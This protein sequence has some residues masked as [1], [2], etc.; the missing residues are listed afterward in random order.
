VTENPPR[1]H[2]KELGK[3]RPWIWRLKNKI[4]FHSKIKTTW[5]HHQW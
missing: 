4:G 1:R 3:L 5:A 2:G